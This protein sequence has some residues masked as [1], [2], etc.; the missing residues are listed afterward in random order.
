MV[1]QDP[2]IRLPEFE[3]KGQMTQR[4][5]YLS[6]KRSWEAKQITDEDTKFA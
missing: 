5:T 4:R 6:V 2:T 1:G 3:E